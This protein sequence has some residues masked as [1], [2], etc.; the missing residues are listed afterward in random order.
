MIVDAVAAK[1]IRIV[2][3][4]QLIDDSMCGHAST[5]SGATREFA[6]WL[7]LLRALEVLLPDPSPPREADELDQLSQRA[8]PTNKGSFDA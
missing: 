5:E 2:L 6:G 7:G 1:P 3:E 8:G 4:V